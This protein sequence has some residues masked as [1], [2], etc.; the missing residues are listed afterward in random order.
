M[1]IH[2]QDLRY[3]WQSQADWLLNIQSFQAAQGE[4]ILLQGS[5]GSGK[6]TLL[7]MLTGDLAPDGAL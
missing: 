1:T 2:L 4:R 6:T 5:S 3:R 7:R